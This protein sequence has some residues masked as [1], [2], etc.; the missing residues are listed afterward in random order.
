MKFILY[1]SYLRKGSYTIRIQT[2]K[3]EHVSPI[4]I[5]WT[6]IFEKVASPKSYFNYSENE[7]YI[8]IVSVLMNNAGKKRNFVAKANQFVA[9]SF[10]RERG[11]SGQYRA[12]YF[13]TGRNWA[14]D[15]SKC[16]RNK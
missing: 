5:E 7:Q 8:K 15:Y 11:K 14:I 4:V 1:L 10:I 16:H 2:K 3:G 12:P 9:V 6:Y 13:L